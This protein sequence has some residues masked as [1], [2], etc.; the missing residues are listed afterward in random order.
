[1][2]LT[3]M[4]AFRPDEQAAKLDG[5]QVVSLSWL[6]DSVKAKKKVA[7]RD[8]SFDAPT[9]S[10][11]A[12]SASANATTDGTSTTN[13][14]AASQDS[15]V[16]SKKRSSVADSGQSEK[17]S[18]KVKDDQSASSKHLMVEVDECYPSPGKMPFS[19]SLG[20]IP[21]LRNLAPDECWQP[22]RKFILT[23][24]PSFGM[25]P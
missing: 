23:T 3:K 17:R 19:C 14:K 1:M 7:E 22:I 24:M 11:T 20:E 8:H 12:D 21:H 2:N 9:A 6:L 10:S 15:K 18:K 5:C 16:T 25:H 4:I 13:D